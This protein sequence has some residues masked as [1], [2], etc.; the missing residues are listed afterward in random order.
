MKKPNL[1]Y[2]VG[3]GVVLLAGCAT[4]QP[5]YSGDP[6]A[7][8]GLSAQ[9]VAAPV[10]PVPPVAQPAVPAPHPT[11]ATVP[12]ASVAV[13]TADAPPAV[14]KAVFVPKSLNPGL[15]QPPTDLF[16]LG[17][18]D[19]LDIEMFGNNLSHASPIVGLDGKIYYSFL[20]GL[21]VWGLTLA[22]TKAKIEQELSKYLSQP[23]VSV[24]LKGVGSKYVWLLGRLTKP[25]IYPLSGS[26]T[27]L[28]A[29]SMAG[30]TA[31]SASTFTTQDLGD[32]RHSFIMRQGRLL[33]V[34]F[35]RLLKQGDMS[36]NIY[37]QP[38]DFVYIPSSLTQEVF[39][40]GSVFAPHAVPYVDQMT[41]VSA[42]AGANGPYKDAY[43]SHVG[44]VRGSLSQPQLITVDYQAILKGKAPNVLLEPGDI[45]YVPLTPYHIL[46]DYADLIVTTFVRSWSA[47][48]GI[49]AAQGS[50]AVGVSVPVGS[51]TPPPTTT[52]VNTR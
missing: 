40:L 15:L 28:E 36:Q 35:S 44:I 12:P 39:V 9:P 24:G 46:T 38:D 25:G 45:V 18:G 29:I 52:T 22:Q 31:K 21:D 30:G 20:P 23:Q 43:L 14:T 3:L 7:P 8:G 4:E 26:M 33:P 16:M 6:L 32:L 50:L 2:W 5:K 49:R 10:K 19:Q 11:F 42:I 13:A 47:N 27:L 41:I 37:L 17:P 51:A 1:P 48:M 34:D